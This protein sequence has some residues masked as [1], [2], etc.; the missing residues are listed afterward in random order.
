MRAGR[1]GM[2]SVALVLLVLA[3]ACRRDE[4]SAPSSDPA[5]LALERAAVWSYPP[6]VSG[7]ISEANSGTFDLVDGIAWPAR[8]PRKG[9]VVFVASKPIASPVLAGSPCPVTCA[10]AMTLLRNASY[11]EV[12]L[13]AKGRSETFGYGSPYG[14][15]GR[16]FDPGG[17]EWSAWIRTASGRAV[18]AVEHRHWG[19]FEF[20]LPIA[21][22]G[23]HEVSEDDRM[24]A[25]HAAWG[26]DAPV[27]TAEEAIAAYTALRRAA[28]DGNLRAYLGHLGFDAAQAKQVRG[29]RGLEEDFRA[30][31]L[32]F[33]DPGE[34]EA[35]TLANGFA[36][37]G[38]RGT[39]ANGDAFANYYELTPCGGQ[40]ILTG[41]GVS[42]Q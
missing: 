19:A 14:G 13:D 18:G 40:L 26:G 36:Q 33:L 2:I 39:D 15:Q 34:P 16:A 10:R 7:R 11:A 27:P 6:P 42:P 4:E 31:A 25:G 23:E 30:Q 22:P 5:D 1:V 35:P 32:R 3:A 8:D 20:D 38:A 21:R 17:R 9:T 29:L 12:T 28:R 41:I 24:A 37:V